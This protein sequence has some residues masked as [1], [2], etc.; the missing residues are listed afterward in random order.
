MKLRLR[1]SNGSMPIFAAKRVHRPFDRVGR[2]RS[3]GAAVRV[4]RRHRREHRGAAEVVRSGEVVHAGVE[5]R[6]EQR[7]AGG[8]ELEV[9]AH[10]ADQADPH[11]GEL[12]VG[13]GGELD[14]LDLGRGRGSCA[15]A[16]SPRSSFHRTGTPW[17]AGERDA[18]QFLG[19]HVELA[20]E[21]ATDGRGDDAH[22]LLG[23]AERE[24]RHHLQDVRHL[25]GRVQRHVAA[26]RL[27]H[28]GDGARLHRHRQQPLLDVALLHRVGGGGERL[29]DRR[30]RRPRPSGPR[31]S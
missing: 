28:R 29:V 30:L 10:V 15:W 14:V 27:R 16:F 6:A 13:V 31:C 3:A 9:G 2:L 24:R 23:D 17:L 7:D 18:Q 12:A 20:A 26:E 25:G 11:G 22:L 21:A 5:E 1:S 19:V 8:D 4:G